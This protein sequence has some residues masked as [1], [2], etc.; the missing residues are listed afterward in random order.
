MCKGLKS[1]LFINDWL[2]RIE[3]HIKN[4]EENGEI[5]DTNLELFRNH[6]QSMNCRM[7]SFDEHGSKGAQ[8][9]FDEM[10]VKFDKLDSKLD[11]TQQDVA[12]IKGYL[13]MNGFTL[14]DYD[15]RANARDLKADA[16]EVKE[17]KREQRRIDNEKN[18]E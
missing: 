15:N 14:K 6:M 8:K 18:S 5:Q 3:G 10:G 16:R 17:E 4:I 1:W 12:K 9:C 7:T 11:V 13:K 2:K